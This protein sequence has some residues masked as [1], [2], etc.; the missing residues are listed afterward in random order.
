MLGV[1]KSPGNVFYRDMVGRIELENQ[2]VFKFAGKM[3][4]QVETKWCTR[5]FQ[6]EFGSE[7]VSG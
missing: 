4:N 5:R 3:P 1:R 7:C 6:A 2:V